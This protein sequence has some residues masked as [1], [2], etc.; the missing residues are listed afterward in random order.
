[1]LKPC[2]CGSRVNKTGQ[3]ELF[4]MPESLKKRMF[5]QVKNNIIQNINKTMDRIIYDLLFIPCRRVHDSL[6]I[7]ECKNMVFMLI[8]VVSPVFC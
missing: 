4:D 5:D 3:S 6:R 1:M 8:Y 7:I 2:M